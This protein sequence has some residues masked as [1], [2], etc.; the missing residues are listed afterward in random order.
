MLGFVE[1]NANVRTEETNLVLC[2]L[3]LNLVPWLLNLIRNNGHPTE[4]K[5]RRPDLAKT[6]AIEVL[7]LME[8][9]PTHGQK[10]Q[11]FLEMFPEWEMDYKYLYEEE[12]PDL[13]AFEDETYFMDSGMFD[14]YSLKDYE[15]SE[16]EDDSTNYTEEV[17]RIRLSGG[18]SLF[19]VEIDDKHVPNFDLLSEHFEAVTL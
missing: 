15:S 2:A 14:R 3:K 5:I 11:S 18:S 1:S 19:E 6:Q 4:H 7:R 10:V 13:E 16:S 9:D 8:R 12:K 17:Y